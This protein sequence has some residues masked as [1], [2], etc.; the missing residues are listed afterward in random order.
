[1][2]RKQK[3]AILLHP[4]R[5]NGFGDSTFDLGARRVKQDVL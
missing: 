1:M 2:E 4:A 3:S 5:G